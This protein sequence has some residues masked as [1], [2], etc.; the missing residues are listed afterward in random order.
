MDGT[1]REELLR[2][3]GRLFALADRLEEQRRALGRYALV[4]WEGAAADHYRDL[5]EQRRATL[6]RHAE[7]VRGLADDVALLVALAGAQGPP[8]A[9]PA[10]S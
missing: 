8:G 2:L 5:V 1:E 4:W 3:V 6:A 7:E 10:A 9:V